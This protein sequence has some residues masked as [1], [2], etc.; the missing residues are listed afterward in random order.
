[1]KGKAGLTVYHALLSVILEAS[2]MSRHYQKAVSLFLAACV[3]AGISVMPALAADGDSPMVIAFGTVVAPPARSL[4]Q[5]F[6]A[7]ISQADRLTAIRGAKS[8]FEERAR[9]EGL[10]KTEVEQTL[11]QVGRLLDA[12]EAVVPSEERCLLGHQILSQ[13]ADPA[14]VNQGHHNTCA[15]AALESRIYSLTPSLAAKVVTDVAINGEFS[16]DR[17]Q[18][19]KFDKR[20]MQPD[21]DATRNSICMGVRSYASQLFQ[22]SAINT[23]WQTQ[24]KDPRGMS[25]P[26]GSISYVQN[27]D[28]RDDA[29][30]DTG[31]RLI[32]TYKD[33]VSEIVTGAS[34]EIVSHPALS[35][36]NIKQL[37][38][39]LA[40]RDSAVMLTASQMPNSRKGE[41]ITL[42]GP[43]LIF[44]NTS[45]DKDSEGWQTMALGNE[46]A[47]AKG[48]CKFTQRVAKA[49]K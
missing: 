47:C 45:E 22:L 44:W 18:S 27:E 49:G 32:I 48:I 1:M 17:G 2:K 30:G 36:G 38:F 29:S 33:G 23:Y 9:K 16:T 5:I 25:V 8:R 35:S 10:S 31:E 28:R 15:V 24:R 12:P 6:E 11:L 40:D 46:D 14:T 20:N 41:F 34:G 21:Q 19:I 37:T 3:S 26:Q 39:A 43:G 4:E 13:A 42:N 7:N